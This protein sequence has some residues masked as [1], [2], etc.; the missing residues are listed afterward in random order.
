MVQSMSILTHAIAI[1]HLYLCVRYLSEATSSCHAFY[2]I[3]LLGGLELALAGG[4][5]SVVE[6]LSRSV[7]YIWREGALFHLLI[8]LLHARL[9]DD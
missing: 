4:V 7:V 8:T 3:Q 9:Q 5:R 2:H 1:L 6:T